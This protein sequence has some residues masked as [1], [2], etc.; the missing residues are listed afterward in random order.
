VPTQSFQDV[1]KSL[2]E[3]AL[4]HFL[5]F[6]IEKFG[7]GELV[8][9]QLNN[10][11]RILHFRCEEQ[12]KRTGF[13]R[14]VVL[15]P[16]RSGLSTYCLARFF[17]AALLGMNMRIAIIAHDEP[18]TITLFN[19]VRLMF[20]HYPKPLR[21]KEG[22][23]G[24]RELSFSDLN[25]RFR[26]GT[27]GGSDI[28]GDQIRHLHCSEVSRWGDSAT[29]YAGALLRNVAI[30]EGTEVILESTARGMGGYFYDSFWSAANGESK[31][32]WEATFF[33]WYVFDDYQ[34]PFG[35]E[36]EQEQFRESIGKDLRYGGEEEER[37]LEEIVTYDLGS[38]GIVS[39]KP[40][41]ENLKWRRLS[42][43]VNCQGS[44]DQMHQDYPTSSREAFLASGRMVFDRDIV[45]RIR[46]RVEKRKAPE[47]YT[48][49][50]NRYD[51]SKFSPEYRMEPHVNGE[52]EVYTE[53]IPQREYRIGV[54][55]AEGIEVNDRDTDWSVAVVMDAHTYEQVAMLRSRIDPDQLAWKLVTLAQYY[56][57][58]MLI[59]ERNNHG[60]VTL[61]SLLDKH[62]YT[63]LY[64]EFRLDE[65]GQ[66][67]TKRVGFL[68]TIKSRPQ[69]ID[70]VRELLREEEILL[71][72]KVLVDE[73]QTFVTLPN[74]REAA[75]A[76]AHDDCVMALALA[77]WGMIRHPAYSRN[78]TLTEYTDRKPRSEY[79]HYHY[80]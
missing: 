59:V 43:D 45:E 19:M 69:L 58:A 38:E 77:C 12:K 13:V 39:F 11:Q 68:T 17:R 47:R 21:P 25:V 67:R 6:R 10:V 29:D 79:R 76:G 54:D 36:E 4:W 57:E 55:V 32:G 34:L 30:A 26:L 16:R 66:K 20:K 53:P 63:K 62:H 65:R 46:Q 41:L 61:R 78:H 2:N 51:N 7:T 22:Y 75:T 72:N 50:T 18:T 1:L 14:Q 49:P 15:K 35:S 31:G 52:L 60:L 48:V 37:L 5:Q 9:F 27:A 40:T 44:L 8:P 33:P 80:V 42:I 28:V 70:T 3:D 23:S 24:K 74:G 73:L 56:N 71:H 64:N